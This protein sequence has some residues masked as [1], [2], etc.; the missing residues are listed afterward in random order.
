MSNTN[1]RVMSFNIK[2]GGINEERKLGATAT[3]RK[4]S[5][6]L[7]GIQEANGRWMD[8]LLATVSDVYDHVYLGRDDPERGE[9]TPVFYKKDVFEL[10]SSG[11]KWLSDTPEVFS[12]VEGSRYTRIMTYAELS[13]RASGERV[14]FVSTHLDYVKDEVALKQAKI[15]HKICRELFGD[16]VTIFITGDF[17][18]TPDTETIKYM[19]TDFAL[20][21]AG[22]NEVISDN[23]PTNYEQKIIIDYCFYNAKC[24]T[25]TAYKV[26]EDKYEGVYPS[27]H[28][29]LYADFILK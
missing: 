21:S 19:T 1:L 17:N 2:V 25:P 16:D 20:T 11:T 18:M 8:H 28:W 9:G 7:L 29:P 3:I 12:V 14:I 22:A 13:V 5:P 24:A 26:I 15:M 10:I 27:D 23:T 4:Y 6:D